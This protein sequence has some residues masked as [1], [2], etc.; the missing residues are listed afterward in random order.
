VSTG[1]TDDM[2]GRLRRLLPR[3]WFPDVSPALDVLL[4]G[5]ASAWAAMYALNRF[6]R[7]QQRLATATG[8]FAD[9]AALDFFSTTRMRRRTNEGDAAFTARARAALLLPRG[10]RSS[11]I[12]AL[13]ALT[14]TA[15]RVFYPASA[16]DTGCYGNAATPQLNTGLAYNG[17]TGGYGSL[18]LPAQCFVTVV[19]PTGG[20]VAN[21]A[22]YGTADGAYGSQSTPG[23][24]TGLAWAALAD[25]VGGVTDDEIYSAVADQQP[26]GTTAW[27]LIL[28]P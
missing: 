4:A 21:E 6:V 12:A 25:I 16:A 2:R 9:I 13:T 5:F 7:L 14:G 27:T 26:I 17:D 28:A 8:V 15:P 11:L 10:T 1:D 3:G 18:S 20:G 22:G 24:D 19:R 23:T